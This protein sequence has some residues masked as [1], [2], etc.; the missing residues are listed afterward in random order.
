MP[1]VVFEIRAHLESRVEDQKSCFE[2]SFLLLLAS[3]FKYSYSLSLVDHPSFAMIT[4]LV[5]ASPVSHCF[6]QLPPSFLES[7]L[8][9]GVC[10]RD[11]ARADGTVKWHQIR[12]ETSLMTILRPSRYFLAQ[13][14]NISFCHDALHV[15]NPLDR[16]SH[17]QMYLTYSRNLI[18]MRI[19]P[20]IRTT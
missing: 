5:C 18:L 15:R 6:L 7:L 13:L 9:C 11:R 19:C 20:R 4:V 8:T 2:V 10:S 3:F 17:V 12:S 16:P 1:L 14:I